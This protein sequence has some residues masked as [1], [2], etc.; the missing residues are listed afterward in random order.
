[1]SLLAKVLNE[2]NY[3][4]KIFTEASKGR[5]TSWGWKGIYEARKVFL[6]GLRW[7]VGDGACINIRED[8]WFPKPFTFK[9]KPLVN[10]PVSMVSNLIDLGSKSWKV[11]LISASFHREDVAQILSI[12]LSRTSCRDRMV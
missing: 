1:M 11:D 3:P 2:K 9:V 5:I 4:G 6:Q 8:P 12:P 7:R 10:L